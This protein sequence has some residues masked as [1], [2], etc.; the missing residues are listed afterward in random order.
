MADLN[1]SLQSVV[2]KGK[3][4]EDIRHKSQ[5]KSVTSVPRLVSLL[6]YLII[7]SINDM[8]KLAQFVKC[9]MMQIYKN[10]MIFIH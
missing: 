4:I 6:K 7:R 10:V 2:R 3:T 5:E 8:T 1:S 9:H